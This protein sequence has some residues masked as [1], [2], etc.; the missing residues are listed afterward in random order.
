MT[1][2]L[3]NL[4][5]LLDSPDPA[6]GVLALQVVVNYEQELLDV[7]GCN[8]EKLQ[9]CMKAKKRFL[10]HIPLLSILSLKEY[11]TQKIQ[12]FNGRPALYWVVMSGGGVEV[13][14][15][16]IL[17]EWQRDRIITDNMYFFKHLTCVK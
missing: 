7:F 6:N 4:L 11:T 8:L 2:E 1:T 5:S 10:W 13:S 12:P 3:E 9:D 17:S 15:T 16:P 14:F